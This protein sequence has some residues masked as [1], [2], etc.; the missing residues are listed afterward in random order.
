MVRSSMHLGQA[1]FRDFSFASRGAMISPFTHLCSGGVLEMV[2][3]FD[4]WN[5]LHE[6]AHIY[7]AP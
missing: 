1:H 6:Y 2:G 7:I 3:I 5:G 4:S